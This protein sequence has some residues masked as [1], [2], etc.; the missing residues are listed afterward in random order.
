MIFLIDQKNFSE[1]FA[2]G[3]LIGEV[4]KKYNLQDDFQSFSQ[5]R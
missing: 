2:S 3:Y 5:S 4:L 1:Q